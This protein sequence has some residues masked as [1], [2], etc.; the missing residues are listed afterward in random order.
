MKNKLAIC[1]NTHT[2]D[3]P[4]NSL[5]EKLVN[6]FKNNKDVDVWLLFEDTDKKTYN[7]VPA[8]IDNKYIYSFK[9]FEK[10]KQKWMYKD[11]NHKKNGHYKKDQY[12]SGFYNFALEHPNY[13][14]YMFIENDVMFCGDWNEVLKESNWKY[15]DVVIQQPLYYCKRNSE[16]YYQQPKQISLSIDRSNWVHCLLNIF[17]IKQQTLYKTLDIVNNLDKSNAL[18]EVLLPTIWTT[19]KIRISNILR[20]NKIHKLLVVQP[21]L[22]EAT[23]K[24]HKYN[25]KNWLIHPIKNY[26]IYKNIVEHTNGII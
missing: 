2:L 24:T 23:A 17:I 3:E 6:D 4:Y 8:E 26:E 10:K 22:L 1:Y 16:W 12:L 14:H 18:A 19:N 9:A 15:N 13:S 25:M 7:E 20:T 11:P 5:F 21:E